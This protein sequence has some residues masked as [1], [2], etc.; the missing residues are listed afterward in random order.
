MT[1]FAPLQLR[2]LQFKNRVAVS[3]MCEYSAKDGHPGRWHLVHLGSRAVGGAAL[4]MTEATAVQ[5]IGRISPWDSGL[6]SA[7]HGRAFSRITKFIREQGAVPAI[8]LA[9]AGRKASTNRPWLGGKPLSASEGGWQ[10]LAP[11][12]I[13]FDTGAPAPQEMTTADID[14]LVS[15]FIASAKWSLDAG[16]QDYIDFHLKTV[17]CSFCQANLADLQ[18]LHHEP[19]PKAQ[20]RRRR[21]FESSAGLLQAVER[22]K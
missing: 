15:R 1:L 6:W 16:F 4:V 8:Q 21:F 12:A 22:R 5:A 7:E 17:S 14:I 11:S 3:P 13:P 9:H 20:A 19:A 2:E 10:T 18:A